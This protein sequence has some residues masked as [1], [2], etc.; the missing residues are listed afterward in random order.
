ME[1]KISKEH[2]AMLIR[3]YLQ[4]VKQFSRRMIIA[5]KSEN[6]H[7]LVN[8][9]PK[10]VRYQLNEGDIL[11]IVLPPERKGEDMKA[12][13]IPLDIVFE[14]DDLLV[15]FK[16]A[17]I[18]TMPSLNHRNGTIANGILNY[19]AKKNIPYTVHIVTRLDLNTSGLM[20]VAKHRFSHSLLSAAQIEGKIR[21]KYK[22]IIHGHLDNKAGV[23]HAPI[24]REEGSI[25]KRAVMETGKDAITSYKVEK[26]LNEDTL[27]HV[28]LITGRTHQIRVHFSYLG[29]PLV[30]DDLYG[31]SLKKEMT[32][33]A[34]HCFEI[35]FM[36]PFKKQVMTF[37]LPLPNDM[38]Q[39]VLNH[40]V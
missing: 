33:Q 22:A 19:Y 21:R 38:A 27:V 34:L 40:S 7:I 35:S 13:D 18:A 3:E 26:E 31:G 6:G 14:D 16:P 1:W 36:H 32:R 8:G 2:D 29:H 28:E 25:I 17:G 15:L 9:E 23:I 37:Q 12:E 30:G 24:E 10:T 20:L 4:V 11:T 39:Y 5:A